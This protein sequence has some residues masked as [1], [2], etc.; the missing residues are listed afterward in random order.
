MRDKALCRS[1]SL[2]EW[3]LMEELAEA[4]LATLQ[5]RGCPEEW[6][7]C[8]SNSLSQALMVAANC[9]Q[10]GID[11]M[12]LL[13]VIPS[14]CLSLRQ[15]MPLVLIDDQQG[16]AE[17][18]GDTD[19]FNL[20]PAPLYPYWIFFVQ[21]GDITIGLSPDDMVTPEAQILLRRPLTVEEAI[22]L[23]IHDDSG[24]V[25]DEFA[26]WAAAS[27]HKSSGE[28]PCVFW[29]SDVDAP[30]LGRTETGSGDAGFATPTVEESFAVAGHLDG[31]VRLHKQIFVKR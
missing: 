19:I 13:P 16:F 29:D 22:A 12:P 2:A 20:C 18:E 10:D 8:L 25:L 6:V 26:V 5:T 17:F 9:F 30:R 28:I 27:R 31:S 7:Y 24:C 15:L 4:Q 21:Y 3:N 14:S 11:G 23:C 1:A